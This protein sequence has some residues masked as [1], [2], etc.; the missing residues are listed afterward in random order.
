MS[1]IYCRQKPLFSPET[2]S[3]RLLSSLLHN[4]FMNDMIIVFPAFFNLFTAFLVTCTSTSES[5]NIVYIQRKFGWQGQQIVAP[6]NS[7][8]LRFRPKFSGH[9][10]NNLHWYIIKFI[11]IGLIPI[12]ISILIQ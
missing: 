9:D 8:V 4:Q 1:R 6:A 10:R 7:G 11:A 5:H 12:L 2:S 3:S